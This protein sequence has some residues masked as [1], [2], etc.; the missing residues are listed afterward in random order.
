M[1][2]S[3]SASGRGILAVYW[4]AMFTLTHVPVAP[5]ALPAAWVFDKPIHAAMYAGLGFLLAR[6]ARA[7]FAASTG[8]N[9]MACLIV[10]A[11]YAVFDE[12]S[13]GFVGRTPS[14]ADALADLIGGLLGVL[15]GLRVFGPRRERS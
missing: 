8:V 4:A 6:F 10:L 3:A 5:G 12:W 2:R 9:V 11:V 15:S 14:A 1:N 7:R 13:Q